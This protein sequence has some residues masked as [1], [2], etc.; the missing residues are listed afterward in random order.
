MKKKSGKDGKPMTMEEL[1]EAFD[2]ADDYMEACRLMARWEPFPD[3]PLSWVDEAETIMEKYREKLPDEIKSEFALLMEGQ[4]KDARRFHG[5]G[6]TESLK[7]TVM[8]LRKNLEIMQSNALKAGNAKRRG[9][10]DDKADRQNRL[11]ELTQRSGRELWDNDTDQELRIGEVADLI[12]DEVKDHAVKVGTRMVGRE[13]VKGWLR[14][15]A[16]EYAQKGGRP[17]T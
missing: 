9:P 2:H 1:K 4:I 13:K 7:V 12:I 11:R 17:K 5:N 16:P 15:I 14:E 10:L 6:D 8:T 3:D